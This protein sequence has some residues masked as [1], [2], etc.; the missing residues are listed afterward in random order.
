MDDQKDMKFAP[1][2]DIPAPD[3]RQWAF[4]GDAIWDLYVRRRL[5][6]EGHR[7][8]LTL[9]TVAFVCAPA[10]ARAMEGLKQRLTEEELYIFKRGRNAKYG[11]VPKN[12]SPAQY[13]A[14]TGMETLLGWLDQRQEQQRLDELMDGSYELLRQ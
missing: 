3:V 4:I 8:G 12:A 11:V 9:K 7:K 14:A 10:Q 2:G 13:H 5:V 6:K 1:G